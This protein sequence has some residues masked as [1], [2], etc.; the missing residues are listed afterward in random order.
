LIPWLDTFFSKT[1]KD[2]SP[3][4][5]APTKGVG[6]GEPSALYTRNSEHFGVFVLKFR[7]FVVSLHRNKELVMLTGS[8]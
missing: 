8:N 4:A 6:G 2:G 1:L 7:I 3:P 5:D